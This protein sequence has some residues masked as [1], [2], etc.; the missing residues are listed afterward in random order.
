MLI[1]VPLRLGIVNPG[2]N[3]T[4]PLRP[5]SIWVGRRVAGRGVAAATC[6]ARQ[7]TATP[8]Q[9]LKSRKKNLK[10]TKSPIHAWGLYAVEAIEKEAR[11]SH[12]KRPREPASPALLPPSPRP[13]RRRPCETMRPWEASAPRKQF[14]VQVGVR[15]L[16][17]DFVIEYIGEYV[18]EVVAHARQKRYERQGMGDDYVFRVNHEMQEAPH[19]EQT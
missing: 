2:S 1:S 3:S 12:P 16:P 4:A 9:E 5:Q 10:F 7:H 11:A 15:G 13:E 14:A 6:A 17:Q 18:R 19:A 8:P